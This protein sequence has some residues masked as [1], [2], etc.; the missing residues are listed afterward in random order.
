MISNKICSSKYSTTPLLDDGD[1]N[2]SSS[3]SET[4]VYSTLTLSLYSS[5]VFDI[6]LA[7]LLGASKLQINE[8]LNTNI[9]VSNFMRHST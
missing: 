3:S 6:L 1:C 4:D 9:L 2:D 8:K 7:S 5:N